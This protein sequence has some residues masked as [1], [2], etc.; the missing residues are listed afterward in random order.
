MEAKPAEHY[1]RVRQMRQAFAE[2]NE[3]LVARLRACDD[4][5][6]E[7]VPEGGWS[8][9]QI[10]WHVAHV[11]TTF[12][13][14]L[15]G[16]LPG[17][18]PLPQGFQPRAWSDV[19]AA[20]PQQLQARGAVVPPRVVRRVDALK[21]L[22]A[23]G[24]RMAHAFDVLTPERGS[25]YGITHPAVGTISLY[26]VGEWATAHVIRHNKQAK[27]VLAEAGPVQA[28]TRR[29]AGPSGAA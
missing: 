8:A 10:G 12:A 5:S 26:Q 23:S 27:T 16:E 29:G 3:R 2:A 28:V 4:A 11:T 22:E 18:Q 15:S 6:A 9:A 25:R 1:A 20:I 13:G 24:V 17:P 14:L 21:E 19:V 7:R